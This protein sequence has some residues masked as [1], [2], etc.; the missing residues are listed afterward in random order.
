MPAADV[1]PIETIGEDG[2]AKEAV[3]FA[4]LAV[5]R[6]LERPLEL[7]PVSGARANG[8]AGALYLP[9]GSDRR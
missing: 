2:D 3:D 5:Q 1:V 8:I 9:P 7:A 6:V 4:W